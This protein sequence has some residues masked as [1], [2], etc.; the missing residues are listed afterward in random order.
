MSER[1]FV[2]VVGFGDAERHSLNTLFRLSQ[3][4]AVSYALWMPGAPEQPRLVM[5]DGDSYE[6]RFVL[7]TLDVSTGTQ[8][9]WMAKDTS[10]TVPAIASCS[11]QRPLDWPAIVQ[12][13]DQAFPAPTPI[14]MDLDFSN[15]GPGPEAPEPSGPRGLIV[16][17]NTHTA[18]YLHAKLSLAGIR[19]VDDVN[20]ASNALQLTAIYSYQVVMVDIDEPQQAD[21]DQVAAMRANIPEGA[22]LIML[23]AHVVTAKER[24]KAAT[25]GAVGIFEK[26]PHPGELQK[27]LE[28]R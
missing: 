8:L 3:E 15:T 16:S 4:Q 28:K 10:N 27:L 21:W 19:W 17:A 5:M 26:P 12:A 23:V 11:F 18:L 2:Q 22:Q 9:M 14:D 1:V 20:H 25:Y 24:A 13:L 6:S 7:E